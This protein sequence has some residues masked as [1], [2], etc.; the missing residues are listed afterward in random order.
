MDQAEVILTFTK[1]ESI[2]ALIAELTDVKAMMDGSYPFEKSRIREH[3]LDF[4]A[5]LHT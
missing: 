2:D 4:D 1:T 5:F 3:E